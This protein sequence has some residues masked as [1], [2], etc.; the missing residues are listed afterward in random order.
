MKLKERRRKKISNAHFDQ[1]KS[2][3]SIKRCRIN[4][5]SL[6]DYMFYMTRDEFEN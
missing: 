2:R 1:T 3:K 5:N 6:E 4:L